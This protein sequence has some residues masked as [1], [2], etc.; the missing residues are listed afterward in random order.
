VRLGWKTILVPLAVASSSACQV[1]DTHLQATHRA[2]GDAGA[3]ADTADAAYSADTADARPDSLEGRPDAGCQQSDFDLTTLR[4][5]IMLVVERSGLMSTP[6][7]PTCNGCYT[8]W[9]TLVDAIENLVSTSWPNFR[10]SL[11]L[12]PSP[13]DVDACFVTASPEVPL[14]TDA[15]A[16]SSALASVGPKGGTPSTMALHQAAG[17]LAS[18]QDGT[19]KV[20]VM[21]MAGT[22]TCAMNDPLQDDTDATKAEVGKWGFPV[23]VVGPGPAQTKLDAIAGA[24]STTARFPTVWLP[25]LQT[26]IRS[27]VAKDA[28]NCAFPLPS[29]AVPGQLVSVLLDGMP[30]SQSTGGFVLSAD[31]AQVIVLGFYCD[32]LGAYSHVTVK[33]GCEG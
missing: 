1:P 2:P 9:T 20:V 32:N 30:L 21:G 27:T 16:I 11:K 25:F 13:G 18:I 3:A 33:V 12:F 19:P 29:P 23:F 24:G 7:A 8:Y 5:D 10:W 15:S 28:T 14:T 26:S 22:P 4:A 31:G 17:Y 6:T